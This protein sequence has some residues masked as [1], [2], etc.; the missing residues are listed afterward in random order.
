MMGLITIRILFWGLGVMVR[1][2]GRVTRHARREDTRTIT[3]TDDD[4]RPSVGI[5]SCE[6]FFLTGISKKPWQAFGEETDWQWPFRSSQQPG[7][8]LFSASKGSTESLAMPR[9]PSVLQNLRQNELELMGSMYNL[10]IGNLI[11]PISSCGFTATSRKRGRRRTIVAKLER[12]KST[13][14]KSTW[15]WE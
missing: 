13:G 14:G 3:R 10:Q 6:S 11:R 8:T 1:R 15:R 9:V 7:S 2:A 12:C 5:H 4:T